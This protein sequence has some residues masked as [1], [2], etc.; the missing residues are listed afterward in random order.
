MTAPPARLHNDGQRAYFQSA[1]QPTMRPDETPYSR[2][3]F[4]RLVAAAALAPGARV[5]ELGA[6]LGRFTRMFDEAGFHIVASDIS[7]GQLGELRR[8]FPHI[9]TMVGAA[10][11]LPLTGP[12]FDAIVGLFMLHHVPD[13]AAAFRRCA[14]LVKP[15]AS[16]RSASPMPGICPSTFRCC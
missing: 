9:E 6:G 7:T 12:P 16:S 5:L 1:D 13:L 11:E 3:H 8:R 14:A 10:D 15:A 4:E 2:R